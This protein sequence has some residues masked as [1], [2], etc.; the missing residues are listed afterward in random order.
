[1][2]VIRKNM[3][4]VNENIKLNIT[5]VSASKEGDCKAVLKCLEKG[6][7]NWEEALEI[8]II[9][10][11]VIAAECI[12]RH[13]YQKFDIHDPNIV[14]FRYNYYK[15]AYFG[16]CIG[17]HIDLAI[18]Y[19]PSFYSN[20]YTRKAAYLAGLYGH[21]KLLML[22][23]HHSEL[24]QFARGLIHGNHDVLWL[25]ERKEI[26]INK[27]FEW[28]LE[29]KNEKTLDSL[30]RNVQLNLD[31]AIESAKRHKRQDVIDNL[32]SGLEPPKLKRQIGHSK[33]FRE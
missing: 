25:L 8:A 3:S 12:Y 4:S 15:H 18:K 5:L 30:A 17:G 20:P 2:K 1:M 32:L 13:L 9:H 6:A 26:G 28:A 24:E 11:K 27:V 10:N 21:K 22:F 14:L 31:S 29:S 16:A 33:L 7:T 23:T 19:R